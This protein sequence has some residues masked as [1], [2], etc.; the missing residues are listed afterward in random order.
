MIIWTKFF[1]HPKFSQSAFQKHRSN[2]FII[3]SLWLNFLII[4]AIKT[5]TKI[6]SFILQSHEFNVNKKNRTWG[7]KERHVSPKPRERKGNFFVVFLFISSQEMV[8]WREKINNQPKANIRYRRT[9]I[10]K[11]IV[12]INNDPEQWIT[13]QNKQQLNTKNKQRQLKHKQK[14]KILIII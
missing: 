8:P 11:W 10:K 6:I 9:K 14:P 13:T 4:L 12:I 5:G 3:F 1:E 2:N 7:Q